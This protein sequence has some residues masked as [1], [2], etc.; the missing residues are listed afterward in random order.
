MKDLERDVELFVQKYVSTLEKL[1]RNKYR[2]MES[3]D[4]RPWF[5]TE[6]PVRAVA[7]LVKRGI[8]INF[9]KAD[10]F[11]VSIKRNERP[12]VK[13]RWGEF[14]PYPHFLTIKDRASEKAE[15]DIKY[16]LGLPK[17]IEEHEQEMQRYDEAILIEEMSYTTEHYLEFLGKANEVVVQT[18]LAAM[19]E[20][21]DMIRVIQNH[22]SD[23]EYML[24]VGCKALNRLYFMINVDMET[25]LFLALNGKYFAAVAILRKIL[26][27]TVRCFY[28]DSL[29]DRV[30]A[31][32]ETDDWVSGGR[33]RRTFQQILNSLIGNGIDHNLTDLLKR[34][35]AFENNSF[36]Q[37]ILSLYGELCL[38]VHLRPQTPWQEDL[39]MSFSEF[40]L[41]KFHRYYLLFMEVMK[42]AEILLVLK[43]PRIISTSS[44]TDPTETY[45]GVVLSK[46]ELD[47]IAKFSIS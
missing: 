18:R 40:N 15:S 35:H 29:Q 9:E 26:E 39:R 21:Y 17:M 32:R 42:I 3:I 27:V 2:Q 45:E 31:E 6:F 19:Q 7:Y 37:S 46:P 20:V 30:L 34:L 23:F 10:H 36:K 47:A 8:I 22:L 43:F 25:S 33:Y 5:P 4:I 44:F 24:R 12:H 13:S 1:V 38:F 14:I 16:L 11:E 41:D 28:L